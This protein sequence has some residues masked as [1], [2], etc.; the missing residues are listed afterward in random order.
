MFDRW[1]RPTCPC[2]L[3]AK[4]WIEFRLEWLAGQFP[5][6]AFTGRPVVEPT[7]EFFPDFYDG[8][9]AAVRRLL[10]RVCEYMG[11]A[12]RAVRLQLV[13]RANRLALVNDEGQPLPDAAGTFEARSGQHL[14]TIDRDELPNTS[15]LVG[16]MAHELAHVR[17]LGEGRLKS[18]EFDNELL[19]DLTAVHLGLGLFLANSP[20]DWMSGY[21]SW[22]NSHRQKPEYMNQPMYGWALAL[23]ARF[24]NE[25]KP[26]WA[27]VLG[28][29]AR[30]ELTQGLRYLAA[31]NDS[32]YLPSPARPTRPR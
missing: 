26:R 28:G 12:P 3:A 9:D 17:L 18:D 1:F 4:E 30:R 2:D 14:I 15:D 11:V 25:S 31:T 27:E 13:A 16:T 5:D 29:P 22:P 6:S 24:R 20:R 8:T 10:D 7:R 32:S 23:L 19:T 21:T